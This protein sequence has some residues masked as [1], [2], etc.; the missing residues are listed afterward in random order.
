MSVLT[1]ILIS[2]LF[3]LLLSPQE[4]PE[5]VEAREE[6]MQMVE[7]AVKDSITYNCTTYCPKEN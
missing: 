6:K 5:K 3:S 4:K 2:T 1:E 7:I